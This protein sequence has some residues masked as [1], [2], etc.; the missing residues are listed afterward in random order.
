MLMTLRIDAIDDQHVMITDGDT[1]RITT[2][3][4][5]NKPL[6]RRAAEVIIA[7]ASETEVK[8][9]SIRAGLDMPS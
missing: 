7:N 4:C 9:A 8:W 5:C 3:P 1:F 2:C 6:T